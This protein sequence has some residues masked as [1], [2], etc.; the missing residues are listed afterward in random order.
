MSTTYQQ[1]ALALSNPWN[2]VVP[3]NAMSV[4]NK[5]FP[6]ESEVAILLTSESLKHEV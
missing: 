6:G 4:K 2:E 5:P 1:L 3:G